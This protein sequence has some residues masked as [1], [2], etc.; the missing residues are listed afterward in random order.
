MAFGGCNT[1]IMSNLCVEMWVSIIKYL[2]FHDIFFIY[3]VCRNFDI[4]RNIVIESFKRTHK[5]RFLKVLCELNDLWTTS[6][7]KWFIKDVY[8]YP[9]W[10][11]ILFDHCDGRDQC[12]VCGSVREFEWKYRCSPTSIAETPGYFTCQTCGFKFE[13]VNLQLCWSSN[14]VWNFP[15]FIGDNYK[16]TIEKIEICS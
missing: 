8:D 4:G 14:V 3:S 15:C 1:N 10:E 6:H 12:I 13:M 7:W 16:E 5:R 2:P 9:R 11:W